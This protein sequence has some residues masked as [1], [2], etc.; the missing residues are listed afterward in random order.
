MSGCNL[1]YFLFYVVHNICLL[2]VNDFTDCV[3]IDTSL[4]KIRFINLIG[5]VL[6]W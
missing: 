5:A 6:Y 3:G 1:T 2:S 4:S